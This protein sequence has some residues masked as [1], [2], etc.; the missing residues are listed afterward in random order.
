MRDQALKVPW[1]DIAAAVDRLIEHECFALWVRAI[2]DPERAIPEWLLAS[3][4]HQYPGLWGSRPDAS[5]IMNLVW[6]DLILGSTITSSRPLATA[7]GSKLFTTIPAGIPDQRAWTLWTRSGISVAKPEPSEI[8]KF[9][10]M[11]PGRL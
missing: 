1:R 2:A 6:E 9:R 5:G 8:P 10:R 3:I 4:E 7:V 11:G